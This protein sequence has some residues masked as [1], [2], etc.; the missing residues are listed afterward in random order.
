MTTKQS[1]KKEN[2]NCK[3]RKIIKKASTLPALY[4]SN[5]FAHM[6]EKKPPMDRN[7]NINQ[8]AF[9]TSSVVLAATFSCLLPSK[10]PYRSVVS[11]TIEPTFASFLIGAISFPSSASEGIASVEVL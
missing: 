2:F 9:S 11:K 10:N 3:G 6:F 1:F 5:V 7:V 8:F 4:D